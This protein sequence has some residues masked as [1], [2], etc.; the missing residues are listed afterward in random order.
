MLFGVLLNH[1]LN[2][3]AVKSVRGAQVGMST[4]YPVDR[5]ITERDCKVLRPDLA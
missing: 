5:L 4:T 1:S 2:V 3:I